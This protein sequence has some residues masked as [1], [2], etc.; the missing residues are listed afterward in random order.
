MMPYFRF[1][2]IIDGCSIYCDGTQLCINQSVMDFECAITNI[3]VSKN[4]IFILY[5]KDGCGFEELPRNN[6]AVYDFK[7]QHLYNIGSIIQE[8]WPFSNIKIYDAF[9]IKNESKV[10]SLTLVKG[11]EYLVCYTYGGLRFIIDITTEK[12][13]QKTSGRF[14]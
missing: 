7:G 12:L 10:D 9:T 8:E 14:Q 1:S 5:T 11:H 4:K 6:I 13:V 2:S 3:A